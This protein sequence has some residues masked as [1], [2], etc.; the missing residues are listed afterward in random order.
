MSIAKSVT[1]N[2]DGQ[3]YSIELLNPQTGKV[4]DDKEI[5]IKWPND[6]LFDGKKVGGI[7]TEVIWSKGEKVLIFGPWVKCR[8]R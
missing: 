6:L 3:K 8:R 4:I 5:R 7:L 1:V 2:V